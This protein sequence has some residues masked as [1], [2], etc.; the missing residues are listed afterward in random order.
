MRTTRLRVSLRDVEPPVVRVIDVPSG[1]KLPEVHDLLQVALGWTDS[2]LHRFDT[3]VDGE[4]G[5]YGVV[6]AEFADMEPDLR[7][8]T[9]A[10]LRDLGD[11]FVYLYDYGDGWEH[12]VHVMGAGE[13]V[14]G[15]IDGEGPCP[16]EDCGGTFG[17]EEF[18]RAW[19]DPGHPE[20]AHL[21][22]WGADW[23]D[24]FDLKTADRL[25]RDTVGQVPA[26][27]RLV[28]S[29]LAGGV[30]LTPGG[31]L[32]RSVV[33]AVQEQRPAWNPFGQQAH[34]EE[35]L[36][37]L[38]ALHELLRQAGLAR[39]SRGVLSPTKAAGDDLEIIRRLRRAL[40]P[41]GFRG[42]LIS[43][44]VAH[45]AA[46]GAA[47]REQLGHDVHPWLRRWAIGGRPVTAADLATEL[48]REFPLM[49][50][51]ELVDHEPLR[52]RDPWR[53]GPSATTL[54]P[55]ATALAHLLRLS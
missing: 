18:R 47:T 50:A 45:L 11:H 54:L 42:V 8:E 35:D 20:H 28:L 14:P 19:F 49:R 9:H 23:S 10:S 3:T 6:D 32:P 22:S 33:R 16:P 36:P 51:L 38:A 37:P 46:R 55:R 15:C 5:Q 43:V 52:H 2:H 13:D 4:Q 34:L 44:A 30:K 26:S 29:A 17:Y 24:T 48:S 25:V 27:V 53:P 21:R 39:L 12:D 7:D 41:D 40:D 1:V 31:R